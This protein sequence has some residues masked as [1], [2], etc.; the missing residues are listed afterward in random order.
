[1]ANLH[2]HVAS[3]RNSYVPA[4][5]LAT[6]LEQKEG[7]KN[8]ETQTDGLICHGRSLPGLGLGLIGSWKKGW[9]WFLVEARVRDPWESG[10]GERSSEASDAAPS[11]VKA[12]AFSLGLRS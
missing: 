3:P 10:S 4:G 8:R 7:K 9:S 11:D 5:G 1:M 6:C 12:E 2:R